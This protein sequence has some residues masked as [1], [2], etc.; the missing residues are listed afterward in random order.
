MAATPISCVAGYYTIDEIEKTGACEKAGRMADRLVKGIRASVEKY[1]LPFV[2]YNQGSICHVDTVGTMHFSIDWSKPWQLPK[3]LKET[4]ARQKEME[5]MGAAYM[6]EG[7]ITLAGNRL[8]TSAAYNEEMI[9]DV[10]GRF[11]KAFANCGKL[12]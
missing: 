1:G 6:A 12:G 9:D 3:V 11:D 8:Y 7:I 10:I 2:V 4:S 5:H